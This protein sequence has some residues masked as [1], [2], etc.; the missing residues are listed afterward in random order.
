MKAIRPTEPGGPGVLK[1][2]E[3]PTPTPGA[4][5]LL[6][7]TRA[8]GVNYI[9]V[10]HR[11]GLYKVARPIPM[12]LE[13]SGVV[14]A[15]GE[16]V[17]TPRVGQRVAW[18]QA[19]GSYAT[20]A[21]VPAARAVDVPDAVDDRLAAALLLQGMTAH[22]LVTDTFALRPGHVALIH[23]AAGG[24]GL[25]LVQLAKRAGARV[26]GTVSTADK[27][28]LARDAGAD[29]I[30]FYREQSVEDEVRRLTGGQGVH[31]AYDSV[32]KNTFEH[33]LRSLRPRG[34][35]V[36][37]GQ[38]SGVVPPL[39]PQLLSAHGSLFLTRPTLG[40]YT[41]DRGELMARASDLFAAVASGALRVRVGA[42]FPL[43]EARAA[44]EALE[45]RA[46]TGKVLLLP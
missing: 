14:L 33:S 18:C 28:Q 41:L 20:H 42:T 12:G 22:Y 45:S 38:S 11:T 32:G 5:E 35:L 24:V 15:V 36:L 21:I 27:A 10:Y 19:P 1:L 25:L 43:A 40:H 8:I 3:L 13:A 44:H 34:Y 26:I 7:E 16:G 23:A 6:V 30:V 17:T 37:F 46:T 4:G 2:E 9:D 39:D 31:V 29:D